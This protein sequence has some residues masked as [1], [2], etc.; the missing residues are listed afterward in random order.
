MLSTR[1]STRRNVLMSTR[2]VRW[3]AAEMDVRI[4]PSLLRENVRLFTTTD[5][6]EVGKFYM[7]EDTFY[8]KDK[9]PEYALSVSPDIY[10]Q[11]IKEAND[12]YSMPLDL[13]F[14]CHGDDMAHSG[15]AH[16]DHVHIGVAWIIVS[17]MI[18]TIIVLSSK[19]I[20]TELDYN[21]LTGV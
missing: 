6:D 10:Q 8:N 11:V 18:V 1:D 3:G 15:V 5:P 2:S 19:Y 4:V 16:E 13:Y 14:C 7:K 12:S 21:P 9:A 20:S 17:L